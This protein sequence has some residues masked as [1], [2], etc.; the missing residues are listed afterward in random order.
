M[1]L[2]AMQ[3]SKV[4]KLSRD[5]T[6]MSTDNLN[7]KAELAA[8]NHPCWILTSGLST[9]EKDGKFYIKFTKRTTINSIR[10][11]RIGSSGCRTRLSTEMDLFH[12]D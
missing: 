10:V 6:R 2:L 4:L 11:K 12:S 3:A 5:T 7:I 8:T 9:L 1:D